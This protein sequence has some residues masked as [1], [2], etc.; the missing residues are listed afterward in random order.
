MSAFSFINAVLVWYS[1]VQKFECRNI[2]EIGEIFGRHSVVA[3]NPSALG[4][5]AVVTSKG[6]YTI[7]TLPRIVTPYHDS[8]EGTRDHGYAVT[9]RECSLLCRYLAVA[10]KGWYVYDLSRSGR[11]TWH[12][13]TIRFSCLPYIHDSSG[14]RNKLGTPW[15]STFEC[16]V[17]SAY[18]D[19][20]LNP[21]EEIW[22]HTVINFLW[23]NF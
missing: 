19:Y 20:L 2:S 18:Y 4:C 13:I 15:I 8:V 9:L 12:V 10:T 14:S 3:E 21:G 5:Y 6:E 16:F 11:A 7:V 17:I 23:F 22:T 1:S